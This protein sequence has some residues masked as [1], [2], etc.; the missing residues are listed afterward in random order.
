MAITKQQRQQNGL[1]NIVFILADWESLVQLEL[2][3]N[4]YLGYLISY[5]SILLCRGE[6]NSLLNIQG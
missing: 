2:K 6:P 3:L 1:A 4:F 5:L